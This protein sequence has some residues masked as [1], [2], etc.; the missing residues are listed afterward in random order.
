MFNGVWQLMFHSWQYA[1]KIILSQEKQQHPIS[2]TDADL[3]LNS[4]YIYFNKC[5]SMDCP[6][7]N[8]FSI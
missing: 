3:F 1:I 2:T 8:N 7:Y 5:P 4:T 6:V